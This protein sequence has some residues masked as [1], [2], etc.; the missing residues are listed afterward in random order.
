MKLYSMC[1]YTYFC[2]IGEGV[3]EIFGICSKVFWRSA[4]AEVSKK[5]RVFE[6]YFLGITMGLLCNS[7]GI[8]VGILWECCG[9]AVG[10]PWD[11]CGGIAV[12]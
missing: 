6:C 8:A 1:A 7:C 3:L 11:C 4:G 9:N 12:M 5:L 2:Y 10:L